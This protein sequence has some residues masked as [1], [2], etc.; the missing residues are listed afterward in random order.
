MLFL[1][2]QHRLL[3]HEEM[4]RGTL[5]QTSVYPREVVSRALELHSAARDP[6]AQPSLAARPS[7]RAPTRR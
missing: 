6:R 7:P 5:T 2:S 1:D 4:F 3:K